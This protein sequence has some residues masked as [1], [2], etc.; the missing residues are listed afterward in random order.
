M[1]IMCCEGKAQLERD[2]KRWIEKCTEETPSLDSIKEK[3]RGEIGT[4][5]GK[6]SRSLIPRG[7]RIFAGI[8][9]SYIENVPLLLPTNDFEEEP[10]SKIIAIAQE[11]I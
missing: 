9:S 6:L 7:W 1:E 2:R 10:R 4:L 5:N 3:L 8:K 11:V